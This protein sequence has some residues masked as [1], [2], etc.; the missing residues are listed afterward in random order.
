MTPGMIAVGVDKGSNEN[1]ST[2]D[3]DGEG[4]TEIHNNQMG[5]GVG[6]DDE[7]AR[8]LLLWMI[9]AR[10]E[11]KKSADNGDTGEYTMYSGV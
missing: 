1:V 9:G 7:D 3:V 6:L 2:D 11:E 8:M 5:T 10:N 4:S